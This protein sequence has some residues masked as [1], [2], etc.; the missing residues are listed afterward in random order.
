VLLV[1]G[2]VLHD[3]LQLAGDVGDHPVRGAHREEHFS[4]PAQVIGVH[5]EVGEVGGV[6]LE[7]WAS[8]ALVADRAGLTAGADVGRLGAFAH[9][10][11][12]PRQLFAQLSD[13]R[14]RFGGLPGGA[15]VVNGVS[16]Q[17]FHRLTFLGLVDLV[18]A[19]GGV[20][21]AVVHEVTQHRRGDTFVGQGLGVGVTEGVAGYG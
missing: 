17:Q 5:A 18:V 19:E 15:A 4:F 8:G 9:R 6:G 20:H 21:V 13:T 16:G 7:V 14:R 3:H 11:G 10:H 12:H 1:S 2:D